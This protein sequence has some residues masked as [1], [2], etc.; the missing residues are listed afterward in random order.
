MIAVKLR[1]PNM[2]KLEMENVPPYNKYFKHLNEMNESNEKFVFVDSFNTYR[3]TNRKE[4]YVKPTWNSCG[5]SFPS[6]A[7]LA[8]DL[9][10][11]LME[12]R[13]FLSALKT[14]GVISPRSVLTATLTSTV[15]YLCDNSFSL[16]TN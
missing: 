1:T 6:R 2:P 12:L 4:N 7:L 10:S 8:N 9:M 13:P 5:C 3:H 11:L 15:S 14:I 16:F